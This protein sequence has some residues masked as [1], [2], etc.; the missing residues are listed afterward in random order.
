[1]LPARQPRAPRLVD[2][3]LPK[4]GPKNL[5]DLTRESA[6]TYNRVPADYVLA[7]VRIRSCE[8]S[9]SASSQG[10]KVPNGFKPVRDR[11]R[12]V[13]RRM[14]PAANKKRMGGPPG[15]SDGYR[16][17]KQPRPY[18]GLNYHLSTS[19]RDASR[20]A[21]RPI[22][23]LQ[24][25]TFGITKS[26]TKYGITYGWEERLRLCVRLDGD[27]LEVCGIIYSEVQVALPHLTTGNA[28]S[29]QRRWTRPGDQP[30]W[31]PDA[32]RAR[33]KPQKPH[34]GPHVPACTL[35]S[36]PPKDLPR[37]RAS[38]RRA[39]TSFGAVAV[40]ALLALV[41]CR[42]GGLRWPLYQ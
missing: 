39:K 24:G 7:L 35:R 4:P 31:T 12:E 37:A 29:P 10:K 20:Y 32:S 38:P 15:G 11:S 5:T 3:P 27:S 41:E 17:A 2:P 8:A 21:Q 14:R 6:R 18:D 16:A 19:E 28:P 13:S 30:T 36:A 9:I 26:D 40:L 25:F 42:R 23:R 34:G 33:N 22:L 1:L